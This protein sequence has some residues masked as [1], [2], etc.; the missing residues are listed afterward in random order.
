M[1]RGRSLVAGKAQV[2]SIWPCSWAFCP[3]K[4]VTFQE[5]AGAWETQPAARKA[6]FHV[7]LYSSSRESREGWTSRIWWEEGWTRASELPDREAGARHFPSLKLLQGEKNGKKGLCY[8]C[9]IAQGSLS[10]CSH[11]E[12]WSVSSYSA[13]WDTRSLSLK[14]K[15]LEELKTNFFFFFSPNFL[16]HLQS[17]TF[18]Y[19]HKAMGQ[20]TVLGGAFGKLFCSALSPDAVESS[21]TCHFTLPSGFWSQGYFNV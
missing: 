18:H 3:S 20:I 1:K 16:Y 10:G 21:Y 17:A 12:A 13:I 7:P 2:S 19:Y 9:Q 15:Y 14:S 4:G 5:G 11:R 8:I 6:G